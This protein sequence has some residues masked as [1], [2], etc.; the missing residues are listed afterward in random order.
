MKNSVH[1]DALSRRTV[2]E[3]PSNVYN[4]LI[5]VLPG[6][7]F[8]RL[9]SRSSRSGTTFGR[10]HAKMTV[11]DGRFTYPAVSISYSQQGMA[12]REQC[13]YVHRFRKSHWERQHMTNQQ[14][15]PRVS[16]ELD[17]MVCDLIGYM[18]DELAEGRDPGTAACAE[19]AG[20]GRIEAV[21]TDDG[22]EACLEAA[23]AFVTQ[24]ARGNREERLGPIERYAIACTGAVELEGAY[25]DAV[26]VSF[27]ERGLATADGA[28]T[29]YSAYVT[30][31]NPGSGDE[32]LW[33]D[34][35]PAGEEPPL[36]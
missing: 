24:N 11:L 25:R 28:P 12:R 33:S 26:L 4:M 3:P 14:Q 16:P 17:E 7:L 15:S 20:T 34:P 29:G 6:H 31:R 18:L 21:F 35:A 8:S 19:D 9:L 23:Q 2:V 10:P 32:F 36:I 13:P 30:Y 27:Y 1:P 5:D 22:E